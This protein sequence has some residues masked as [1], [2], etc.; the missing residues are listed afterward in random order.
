MEM[1]EQRARELDEI[2]NE[3]TNNYGRKELDIHRNDDSK[4]EEYTNYNYLDSIGVVTLVRSS[5]KLRMASITEKGKLLRL[6]GGFIEQYNRE[7]VKESDRQ[8]DNKSKEWSIINSKWSLGISILSLVISLI[9][10]FK[11][12][13][14]RI[15]K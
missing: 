9:A 6:S 2:L 10:L 7:K 15:L 5:G 3:L 4:T 14:V 11:D 13:L 12:E 1:T 8:L